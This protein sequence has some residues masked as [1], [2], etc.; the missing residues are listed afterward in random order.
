[1]KGKTTEHS[2]NITTGDGNI[3]GKERAVGD[4]VDDAG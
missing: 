4:V 1:M 3:N 2:T